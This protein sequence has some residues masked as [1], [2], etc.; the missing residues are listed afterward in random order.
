MKTK[1]KN[2][3]KEP[4]VLWIAVT[5]DRYELP[6]CVCDSQKDLAECLGVT[7]SNIS[8]LKKRKC[9]S[10]RSK[11]YIYKVRNV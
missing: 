10:N 2:K 11:Y 4:K 6:M 3:N 5:P 1:Q 7:V 8:H 9:R